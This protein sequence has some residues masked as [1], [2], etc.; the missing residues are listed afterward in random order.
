MDKKICS[1][2][3]KENETFKI[4]IKGNI[5]DIC[6]DCTEQALSL[7]DVEMLTDFD[8]D[9]NNAAI[10]IKKPREIKEFL[11]KYVVG[12]E[13][14]KKILSVGVY[15]H[16]KRIINK[17]NNND[18]VDIEK[19]NILLIGDTGTGK[20]YL[21]KILARLLDVPFCIADATSL[22]EAGYVGE[23]VESIITRLLQ[24]SKN[25]I[26]LAERGIVYIDEIDKISRKSEN[27]SITRDVSG[28]GVQQALLKLLEGTVVNV[29]TEGGRRN[30]EQKFVKVDTSN[31]LFICGGAFEGLIDIIKERHKNLKLG[32]NSVSLGNNT[33][34]DQLRSVEIS[35]LKK[36]GLIPEL[37]GRLPI[38]GVLDK[39]DKNVLLKILVE[40][41]NS[42][43]NQ[44]KKLFSFDN[45][46]LSVTDDALDII[47]DYAL[48]LGTGARGLKSICERIFL[49]LMY[50]IDDSNTS[51]E[52]VVD[53]D[54]VLKN[55]GDVNIV[56]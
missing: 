19:S 29:S 3:N 38:I 50:N 54:F 35:D 39:I 41:K 28:E 31:I 55:I 9:D 18:D 22:T 56:K 52:I 44:Y 42:I 17:N 45:I 51:R 10:N 15:N 36:F 12:Q 11:D 43:I 16:Y 33:S 8:D 40:P 49:D 48:K 27:V 26:K 7:I 46:S 20:T 37:L 5:V 32:F 14:V 24:V 21:A 13:Y 34:T 2:C 23:D 47:A 53:K 25:K 1:F 30:P 4:N 6:A